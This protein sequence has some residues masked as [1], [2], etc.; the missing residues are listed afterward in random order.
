M[1]QRKVKWHEPFRGAKTSLWK[2]SMNDWEQRQSEYLKAIYD[3]RANKEFMENLSL[4]LSLSITAAQQ[5]YLY[6]F[7]VR[8]GHSFC[9]FVR[10]DF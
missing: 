1:K 10:F 8:K 7:S 9:N 2:F 5:V 6:K 3:I 4:Q